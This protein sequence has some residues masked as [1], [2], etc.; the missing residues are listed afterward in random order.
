VELVFPGAERLRFERD[1]I[2]PLAGLDPSEAPRAAEVRRLV[3]GLRGAGLELARRYLDG[4]MTA[5]QVTAWLTSFGLRTPDE[6]AKFVQ[7]ADTYRSYVVNYSYGEE[8]VNGWLD[9]RAGKDA[10]ARWAAFVD[11]IGS[12]RLPAALLERPAR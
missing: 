7:F 6:A 11:L 5:A 9:A 4:K 8:L 2:F 1:V 3:K 10:E 12:S